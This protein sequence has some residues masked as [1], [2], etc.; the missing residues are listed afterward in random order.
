MGE[1]NDYSFSLTDE[2]RAYMQNPNCPI[3]PSIVA[4]L[5]NPAIKKYIFGCDDAPRLLKAFG[6]EATGVIDVI[7]A[8]QK[9]FKFSGEGMDRKFGLKGMCEYYGLPIEKA[10]HV[11]TT[12]WGCQEPLTAAQEKYAAEDAL[13]TLRVYKRIEADLHE[14]FQVLQRKIKDS[15]QIGHTQ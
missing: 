14:I 10:R 5:Q 12:N 11:G 15:K 6:I 3:P 8:A 4:V 2:Q 1:G 13:Y 7:P 9:R